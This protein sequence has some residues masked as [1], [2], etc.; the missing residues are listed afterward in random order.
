MHDQQGFFCKTVL[1][2]IIAKIAG[3][4]KNVSGRNGLAQQ[5]GKKV[6]A[7]GVASPM[8]QAQ[9]GGEEARWF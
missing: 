7:G 8:G 5:Q 1:H 2:W 4:E 3:T 6:G 9:V